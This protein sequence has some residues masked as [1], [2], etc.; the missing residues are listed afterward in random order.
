M[1]LPKLNT[2]TYELEVFS[3]DE[4]KISYVLGQRRKDIVDGN[5]KQR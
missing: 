3:T 5:G 1:A 2:P 4:N